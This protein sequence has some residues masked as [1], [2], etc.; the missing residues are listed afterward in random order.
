MRNIQYMYCK[1]DGES[2]CMCVR[3]RERVREEEEDDEERQGK[4]IEAEPHRSRVVCELPWMSGSGVCSRVRRGPT[5]FP[6]DAIMYPTPLSLSIPC[7]V[8]FALQQRKLPHTRR[9]STRG[10]KQYGTRDAGK[11]L[12]QNESKYMCLCIYI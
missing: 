1:R 12:D 10:R 7:S 6:Y 11:T 3:E 5:L 2:V 9:A 4:T 8:H